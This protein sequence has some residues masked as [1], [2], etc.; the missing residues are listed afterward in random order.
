MRL[1]SSSTHLVTHV[2]LHQC[3]RHLT[4]ND[5]VVKLETSQDELYELDRDESTELSLE[6][7]QDSHV[8]KC[9]LHVKCKQVKSTEKQAR[10]QHLHSQLAETYHQLD[11]LRQKSSVNPTSGKSS[12]QLVAVS[13][14]Q[15]MGQQEQ[16]QQQADCRC[17]SKSTRWNISQ[18]VR[19]PQTTHG[20]VQ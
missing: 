1:T 4:H 7:M 18:G 9:Q 19:Q 6:S 3:H 10:M 15:A 5:C 2:S 16:L 11:L 13:T 17:F 14:P 12:N 8:L 20:Q